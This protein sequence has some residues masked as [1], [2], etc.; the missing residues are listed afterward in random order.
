[1]ID[2]LLPSPDGNRYSRYFFNP[3]RVEWKREGGVGFFYPGLW[4]WVKV[5]GSLRDQ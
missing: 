2:H 3:F 4:P 5:V 1:M